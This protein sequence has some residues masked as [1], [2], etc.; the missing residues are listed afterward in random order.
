M[1]MDSFKYITPKCQECLC[2]NFHMDCFTGELTPYC[3]V[4]ESESVIEMLEYMPEWCKI[5]KE[6]VDEA[7]AE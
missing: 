2:Y 1:T 6:F 7:F 5:K 3:E 4:A